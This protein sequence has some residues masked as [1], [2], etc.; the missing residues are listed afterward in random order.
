MLF[1]LPMFLL[2][3]GCKKGDGVFLFSLED[4]RALGLETANQIAADPA[5]YPILNP[6]TNAQAYAYLNEMKTIIFINN[7]IKYTIYC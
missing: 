4:D 3:V 6:A 5:T 2:F 7:C 1:I